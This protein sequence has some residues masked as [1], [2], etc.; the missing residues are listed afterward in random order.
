[1][2]AV[3]MSRYGGPETLDFEAVPEPVAKDSEVVVKVRRQREP[4][5]PAFD[6]GRR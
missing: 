5:R 3:V 2:T 6:G 4:D 1:M